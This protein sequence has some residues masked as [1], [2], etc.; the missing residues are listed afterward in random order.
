MTGD[1]ANR[2]RGLV[3]KGDDGRGERRH[4]FG[5]S[6]SPRAFGHSGVGG[7]I[8]WADPQSGTELLPPHERVGSQPDPSGQALVRAQQA[9]RRAAH[10]SGIVSRPGDWLLR[11]GAL[12]AFTTLDVYRPVSRRGH[13]V[14][15][16]LLQ[17]LAGLGTAGADGTFSG[18]DDGRAGPAARC[19]QPCGGS[20]GSR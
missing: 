3:I 18:G 14:A 12:E 15:A 7:Q 5:P 4:D 1:P 20:P 13:A 9:G 16:G 8:A 17:H 2:S 10:R 11:A 6:T 19:A